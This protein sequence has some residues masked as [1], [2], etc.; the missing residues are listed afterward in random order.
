MPPTVSKAFSGGEASYGKSWG[1][2]VR[3]AE[4]LL[5]GLA[6]H[7]LVQLRGV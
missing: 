3:V 4:V 6:I 1:R 5:V 7:E 2:S